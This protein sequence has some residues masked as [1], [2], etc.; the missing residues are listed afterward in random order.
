[1]L[2]KRAKQRSAIQNVHSTCHEA[3]DMLGNES[4]PIADDGTLNNNA[5]E[6]SADRGPTSPP[7]ASETR[8]RRRRCH[9]PR[10]FR[11]RIR[12]RDRESC[13]LALRLAAHPFP[14]ADR[15]SGEIARSTALWST[16]EFDFKRSA[17]TC[18]RPARSRRKRSLPIRCSQ[19]IG[20]STSTVDAASAALRSAPIGYPTAG[21]NDATLSTNCGYPAN[22]TARRSQHP[23][24]S[25]TKSASFP[26]PS[27]LK[28]SVQGDPP[29]RLPKRARKIVSIPGNR[30]RNARFRHR[31]SCPRLHRGIRAR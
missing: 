14:N 3:I 21:P 20:I 17:E 19:R 5:G 25:E 27:T 28:F 12:F 9:D 8:S 4:A 10:E 23:A 29:L 16:S 13:A 30:R 7:P 31:H 22:F 6:L 24:S 1:M 11:R 26:K 2:I 15:P 18:P